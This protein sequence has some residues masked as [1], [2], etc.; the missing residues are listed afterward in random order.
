MCIKMMHK[1]TTFK[2]VFQY[3]V[4]NS[5]VQNHSHFCTNLIVPRPGTEPT[6][7]AGGRGV[8]TT[9]PPGKSLKLIITYL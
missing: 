2:N 1:I 6:P 7:T 8:L 9:G 3:Q 4:A 5:T